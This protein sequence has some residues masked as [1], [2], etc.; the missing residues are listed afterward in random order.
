MLCAFLKE[1]PNVDVVFREKS[2]V[3]QMALLERRE[4]DVGIWRMATNQRVY[5]YS[6]T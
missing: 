3:M 4:L 2:P 1:H 6:P 5:Q